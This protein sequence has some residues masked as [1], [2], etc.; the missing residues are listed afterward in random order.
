M[1]ERFDILQST[2]DM[3]II[4]A[5]RQYCCASVCKH[6]KGSVQES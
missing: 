3:C 5:Q 2:L 4:L 6:H 1:L